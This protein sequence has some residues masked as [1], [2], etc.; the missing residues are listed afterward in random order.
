MIIGVIREQSPGETRV[1]A[2]PATVKQLA[3]LGYEVVV[4]T[5][6][7]EL[8]SFTDQA[9]VDAGATIGDAFVGD[10]VLSVNNPL[11]ADRKSVV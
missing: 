4:E 7:G 10:I 6:A 5:G 9:Y 3:K 8:S 1:A 11:P 2:T